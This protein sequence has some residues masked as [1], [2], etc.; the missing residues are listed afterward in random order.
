MTIMAVFGLAAG[1]CSYSADSI[2]PQTAFTGNWAWEFGQTLEIVCGSGS[3]AQLL[4][5]ATLAGTLKLTVSGNTVMMATDDG[6]AL[7]FDIAGDTASSTG[8]CTM[9]SDLSVPDMTGNPVVLPTMLSFGT[10]SDSSVL[11]L[12]ETNGGATFEMSW[13]MVADATITGM[14]SCQVQSPGPDIASAPV[15]AAHTDTVN[16]P[17]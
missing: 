5:P 10:S 12:G 15:V 8:Q 3:A 13:F 17:Q 2:T 6:C 9:S 11:S 4:P 16:Y 7:S 1:A 14:G